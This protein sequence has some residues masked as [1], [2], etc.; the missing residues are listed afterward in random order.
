MAGESQNGR[1][2]RLQGGNSL[3]VKS[4]GNINVETG[5]LVNI[6]AGEIP[7]AGANAQIQFNAGGKMAGSSWLTW[8]ETLKVFKISG[9]YANDITAW[10]NNTNTTRDSEFLVGESAT[11]RVRLVSYGST[12]ADY[13]KA[14][15]GSALLSADGTCT[16][17]L[18]NLFDTTKAFMWTNGD[19]VNE[20]MVLSVNGLSILAGSRV[21][22]IKTATA[23]LNFAEIAAGAS[24][25]LTITITGAAAN[26]SVSLGLPTAPEAG[27]VFTAFVSAA[28]TVTV[29]AT[30]ITTGA[31]NPASATFR[32]TVI[33]F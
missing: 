27:I 11:K 15:A 31:I 21:K 7:A 6:T 2:V 17:M 23:T 24:E 30:N 3:I 25:D 32:A 14:I 4:G 18:F 10:V 13:N 8:D 22:F 20:L 29:R 28:D 33:G 16:R 26:Y 1:V 9:N 12:H 19:L 5:G